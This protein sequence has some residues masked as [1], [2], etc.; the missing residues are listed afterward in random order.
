[1]DDS[2]VVWK[3]VRPVDSV[4]ATVAHQAQKQ[5]LE[6]QGQEQAKNLASRLGPRATILSLRTKAKNKAN[7]TGMS[8]LNCHW[9]KIVVIK[10][11]PKA[12][13]RMYLDKQR[14]YVCEV[15]L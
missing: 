4:R 5:G 2:S 1:M 8:L 6:A 9:Y 7:L 15:K 10:C 14:K 11:Y 3:Y 13:S 12:Y